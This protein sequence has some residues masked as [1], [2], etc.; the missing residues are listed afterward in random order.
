MAKR[1]STRALTDE[2]LAKAADVIKKAIQNFDGGFDELE[3][4]IGMYML[5]HYVG[6]KVLY[7]VHS[8]RTIRRYEEILGVSIREVFPEEASESDR[9][10]AYKLAKALS[11]FWKVVSGEA[12][13]DLDK[14]EKKH[15]GA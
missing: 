9:S 2:E 11:N 7:L 3:S 5:G 8:K 10:N 12:K 6:W 1:P 4:A 13:L 15:F 14:D